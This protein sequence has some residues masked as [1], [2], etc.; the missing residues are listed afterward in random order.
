MVSNELEN[1]SLISSLGALI[2]FAMLLPGVLGY[3][4]T[5]FLFS[6]AETVSG[7]V[8]GAGSIILTIGFISNFYGHFIGIVYRRILFKNNFPFEIYKTSYNLPEEIAT[9]VRRDVDYW[10]SYY[11]WYWNSAIAIFL[12]LAG[13][14]YL[15]FVES[16]KYGFTDFELYLSILITFTALFLIVIAHKILKDIQTLMDYTSNLHCRRQE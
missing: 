11:C 15:A 6:K 4:L 12:V 3:G 8:I 9:R 10:F 14:V 1:S 13:K 2:V 7:T 5:F 16:N